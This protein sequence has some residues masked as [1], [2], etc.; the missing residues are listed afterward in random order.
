MI[1]LC[2][3]FLLKDRAH[4]IP[5]DLGR[6]FNPIPVANDVIEI[7]IA[8]IKKVSSDSNIV[9]NLYFFNILS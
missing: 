9:D 8:P 2:N 1:Y 4:E 6:I 3:N 7:H 5:E